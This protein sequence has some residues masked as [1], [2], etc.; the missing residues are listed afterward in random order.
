M[1]L[2][3]KKGRNKYSHKRDKLEK[4]VKEWL[5]AALKCLVIF[6]P[7]PNEGREVSPAVAIKNANKE[8]VINV[9]RGRHLGVMGY[10]LSENYFRFYSEPLI[11][12]FEKSCGLKRFDDMDSLIAALDKNEINYVPCQYIPDFKSILFQEKYLKIKKADT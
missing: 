5:N 8:D 11:Q 10:D 1:W 2:F 4:E 6:L 12:E 3:F 7:E 9:C